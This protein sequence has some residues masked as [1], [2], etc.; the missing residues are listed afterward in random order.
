MIG[1]LV[2]CFLFTQ[3]TLKY[4]LTLVFT[5]SLH[6]IFQLFQ[7][8]LVDVAGVRHVP[9]DD[10]PL[11]VPRVTAARPSHHARQP[12]HIRHQGHHQQQQQQQDPS[13]QQE[14]ELHQPRE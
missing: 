2:D 4:C 10:V 9:A 14:T 12:L 5:I 13:S 6:T 8:R 7:E 1:Y 11:A 3:H